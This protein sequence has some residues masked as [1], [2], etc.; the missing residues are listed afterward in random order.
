MLHTETAW[1]QAT[2]AA[3]REKH[4]DTIGSHTTKQRKRYD[5]Y[6]RVARNIMI[7]HTGRV[8][9]ALHVAYVSPRFL[10]SSQFAE[11]LIQSSSCC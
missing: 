7:G 5:G 8:T 9:R 10:L 6:R 1:A 3:V 11:V 2:G 4:R